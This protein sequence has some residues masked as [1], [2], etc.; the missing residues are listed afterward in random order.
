MP[1][2]RKIKP[3]KKDDDSDDDV[4]VVE[5]SSDV[6]TD[7]EKGKDS[8]MAQSPN[9]PAIIAPDEPEPPVLQAPRV[10]ITDAPNPKPTT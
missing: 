1:L 6:P 7:V 5:A 10:E 4:V 8:E 2:F 3:K 9:V